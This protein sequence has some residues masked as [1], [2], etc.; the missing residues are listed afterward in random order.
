MRSTEE[1]EYVTAIS[2]SE[3]QLADALAGLRQAAKIVNDLGALASTMQRTAQDIEYAPVGA[4]LKSFLDG[5]YIQRT[6]FVNKRASE[7]AELL[8][9]LSRGV[10][11]L[12]SDGQKATAI[13]EKADATMS[14]EPTT[15]PSREGL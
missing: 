15:E 11:D 5:N 9:Q 12:M 2:D 4:E 8:R 7:A 1:T 13:V 14:D 10:V 6:G 3:S